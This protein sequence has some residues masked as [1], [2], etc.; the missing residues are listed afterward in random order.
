VSNNIKID[1]KFRKISGPIYIR[2][3]LLNIPEFAALILILIV[4][5]YWV[6]IPVW[7][8][9]SIIG[10][11]IV[12]DL[13]LFPFIWRA[14]DWDRAG[15]SRS[16]I[17][18]RGV[19]REKLKKSEKGRRLKRDRP[20]ASKIWRDLRYLLYRIIQKT[21]VHNSGNLRVVKSYGF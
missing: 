12:K 4:I 11:W 18:E 9:W 1:L 10:F 14:Y 21:E 8:F 17:G 2:Y 13:I 19:A 6:V 16:M 15:K 7:L 3:I 5:Q 20:F